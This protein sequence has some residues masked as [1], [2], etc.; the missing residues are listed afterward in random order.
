MLIAPIIQQARMF[1]VYSSN[2]IAVGWNDGILLVAYSS[3]HIYLYHNVP[4][5]VFLECFRVNSVGQWLSK[6]LKNYPQY[7]RLVIEKTEDITNYILRQLNN[8]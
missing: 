3:G 4:E 7:Q 5:I 8:L 2:I 1:L 6:E